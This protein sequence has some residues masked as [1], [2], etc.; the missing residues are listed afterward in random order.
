M[1]IALGT[2]VG[3]S[4]L[5]IVKSEENIHLLAEIGIAILLFIVGLK[6]DLR[7]IKNLGKIA[8][9]AGMGQVLFTSLFGFCIGIAAGW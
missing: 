7:I 6:L 3:P 8:L 4:L 1:F 9:L 5:N 2:L